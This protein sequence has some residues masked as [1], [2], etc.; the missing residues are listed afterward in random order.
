ME[1]SK[2]EGSKT[3]GSN[4]GGGAPE[5]YKTNPQNPRAKPHFG[6]T[7]LLGVAETNVGSRVQ[8]FGGPSIF[9]TKR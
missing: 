1:G 9:S 5:A 6:E 3:E 7:S 2:T 8:V 4:T